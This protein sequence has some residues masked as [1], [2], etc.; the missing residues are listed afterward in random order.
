[1]KIHPVGAEF[2]VRTKRKTDKTKV[3]VSSRNFAN[4]PKK[5]TDL[6]IFYGP[7]TGAF[8]SSQQWPFSPRHIIY[9]NGIMYFVVVVVVVFHGLY[10]Y[11]G[12]LLL[13][14]IYYILFYYILFYN[15]LFHR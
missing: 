11:C 7:K 9:F 10:M 6:C 5:N 14:L 3:I 4:A 2:S 12:I 13:L 1:M 15:F 8:G